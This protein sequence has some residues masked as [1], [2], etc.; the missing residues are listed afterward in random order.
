MPARTARALIDVVDPTIIPIIR[1]PGGTARLVYGRSPTNPFDAN[2]SELLG[3]S[4]DG[5][6]VVVFTAPYCDE[7]YGPQHPPRG[8]YLVDPRTL[9]R[10]Y[11]TRSA[12]A[13]W[14]SRTL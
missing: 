10:T 1:Y 12:E 3:W 14:S 2:F 4:A 9:A 11:V 6:M 5:R 7:P 13:M 8:V